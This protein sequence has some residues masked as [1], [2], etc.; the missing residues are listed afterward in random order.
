M[1][2]QYPNE[3]ATYNAVSQ[4]QM[5]ANAHAKAEEAIMIQKIQAEIVYHNFYN[6]QLQ[7]K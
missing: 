5:Y 6:N 2:N 4:E 3:V 7:K 1:Y